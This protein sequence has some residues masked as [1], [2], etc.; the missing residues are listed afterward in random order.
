[1]FCSEREHSWYCQYDDAVA[2][3]DDDDDDTDDDDTDSGQKSRSHTKVRETYGC[4]SRA[5]IVLRSMWPLAV[6]VRY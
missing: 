3:A 5:A 6:P 2:A 1:M 4:Q